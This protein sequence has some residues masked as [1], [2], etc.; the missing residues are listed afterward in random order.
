MLVADYNSDTLM[1]FLAP[2]EPDSSFETK[3]RI[4]RIYKNDQT[5]AYHFSGIAPLDKGPIKL[6][7]KKIEELNELLIQAGFK[8]ELVYDPEAK[9]VIAYVD[10]FVKHPDS[11]HL[12]V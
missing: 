6:T 1:T 7:V 3:K 2:E 12:H 11:D 9:F 10:S 4:T 5:L 8:P